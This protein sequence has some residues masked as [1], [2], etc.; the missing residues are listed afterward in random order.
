VKIAW[1]TAPPEG[2]VRGV[3]RDWIAVAV[4]LTLALIA[5]TIS[6][7]ADRA[8]NVFYDWSTTISQREAPDNIVIVAIDDASLAALGPWPWPR[9]VHARFL[10]RLA[11]DR[12]LA[13]V[14]DVLFLGA[15]SRSGEDQSLGQALAA[16]PNTFAPMLF[17][18][19]GSDGR[20]Y[21]PLWPVDPVRHGA[22]IGHA[23]VQP[24]SDG[25]V[26]RLDLAVDGER[27]WT[28]IAALAASATIAGRRVTSR[29]P[30]FTPRSP[31]APLRRQGEVLISFGGP[32]GHFRTASFISVLNGE[33]PAD[34]LRGAYVLVGATAPASGDA[35]ST[36]VSDQSLMPGIEIQANFIDTLLSGS[37]VIQASTSLRLAMGL[38]ALWLLMIGFLRLPPNSAGVLGVALIAGV[39]AL[40]AG[41]LFLD[42]LWVPPAATLAIL[43]VALPLWTW[44]RLSRVSAYMIEELSRLAADPDFAAPLR[45]P[46]HLGQDHIATQ[47]AL[48]RDT[49][50]RV[51]TLRRLVGAA[52]RSLPDPTVLVGLD[53]GIT[54]AD[55][56]ARILFGGDASLA[57]SDIE[58]FFEASH[59]P[60]FTPASF[61]DP[62]RRWIG[63][64]GGADGSLREILHVPWQDEQ[65]MPLGWVVRFADITALR[66][67]EVAREEALQLLTHDMRSPQASILALVAKEPTA[68]SEDTRARIA[69]Y[70]QRTI[71]LADGFLRLARADAGNY[72][73]EPT[74]IA[75]VLTEAVDDLWALASSR[76]VR[77]TFDGGDREYIIEGHRSLLIRVFT[78]V[79]DNA[80]K[81]SPSGSSIVCAVKSGSGDDHDEVVCTIRDHGPGMP[82]EVVSKLFQRFSH[83]SEGRAG[84]VDGVGLGLAFVHSVVKGHDGT[85][86]VHSALGEGTEFELTFPA[87]PYSPHGAEA[88]E[89]E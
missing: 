40:S 8:D 66:R 62:D 43:V 30:P 21:D 47:V 25:V 51:R 63:E 53:G 34:V 61:E 22:T 83:H 49:V 15:S 72:E 54:L 16:L 6:G 27:R 14:Y 3:S 88:D 84:P 7:A 38:P 35:F 29:S 87:L 20:G 76:G 89:E 24:D 81:F 41:L 45:E 64:R 69:H 10:Q 13:V 60:P 58:R 37:A 74:D 52:V 32:P 80:V 2:S 78:N 82:P 26:R 19:P 70:A 9:A 68:M 11:E 71:A 23:L 79:L 57:P 77:I 4:G 18:T 36:P 42:H 50:A 46:A 28:H 85:V 86:V 1:R 73:R 44:R 75:D 5:L 65:G 17:R 56:E 39:I 33:T 12:P 59:P 55:A 67:A 48:M 31:S